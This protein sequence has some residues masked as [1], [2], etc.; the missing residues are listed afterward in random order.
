MSSA[1]ASR[2][3]LA[4]VLFVDDEPEVLEGISMALRKHFDVVT[5]TS[6]VAGMALLK[7]QGPFVA[8]VSDMRVP[9]MDGATFLARAREVAPDTIRLVLTGQAD[10]QSAI[11]AVNDGQ[12]FRFLT[13]PCPPPL[14]IKALEAAT[15]QH[16]LITSERVLLEQTLVG[17]IKT[18]AEIL[19]LTS[20]RAFGRAMR[21][22]ARVSAIAQGLKRPDA[23]QL[24]IAALLSHLA[25]VTLPAP[26]AEKLHLQRTLGGEERQL[27]DRLPDIT[28]RLL[29]PIPRLETVREILRHVG[30]P[31]SLGESVPWGSRLL[32]VLIDLDSLEAQ[33]FGTPQAIA[34]LAQFVGAYDP[35]I[36]EHAAQLSPAPASFSQMR[37]VRPMELTMGMILVD[38]MTLTSGEVLI[39]HNQPITAGVIETLLNHAR[40]LNPHPV[41]VLVKGD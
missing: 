1:V 32:K 17:V 8:V 5:A 22:R 30:D 31:L 38:D 25:H 24:E 14:L 40:L 21:L 12:I 33:G 35:E 18:L 41:R 28:E 16:R 2:T 26:T 6:A 34:H 23:W 20:P 19:A 15:E 36:L 27:V 29:A 11:A 39:P 37:T 7:T 4:R 9:L 3:D 13:K 10:I